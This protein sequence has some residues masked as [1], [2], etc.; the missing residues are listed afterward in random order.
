MTTEITKDALHSQVIVPRNKVFV[1]LWTD[2]NR[3]NVLIGGAGSGKSFAV[4][5]RYIERLFTQKGRNLLV[6]RKVARTNRYST[7]AQLKQSLRLYNLLD[8]VTIRDTDM[9]ILAP[10]GNC[11]VFEGLDDVEKIKSITLDSGPLTDIWFEEASEGT[12]DDF[13]LLN[14][15]LRGR[16]AWPFQFTLTLNPISVNHWV[17]AEFFDK[18]K[19]NATIIHSTYLD[20]RFIDEEYKKELEELKNTDPIRYQ[21]YALGEWGEIGEAAFPNVVF[22]PCPYRMEDMDSLAFGMDFGYQHYHA[23][24]V[25]GM[26]DGNLYALKELYVKRLLTSQIIELAKTIFPMNAKWIADS[27]EPRTIEEW[28]R[29]G[30]NVEAVD[31]G[32][33]D[34]VRSGYNF[35][36]SQK[37]FIDDKECPGL[38]AE[39]IGANY[40]KDKNGN[41]TE[42]IFSYHD[43]ALA[44]CRYAVETFMLPKEEGVIA[45][46][47]VW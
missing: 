32:R 30:F 34:F 42:E 4:S 6:V 41:P 36:R 22:S 5:Q 27:A 35:L 19:I 37:W 28:R 20:N 25:L 18:P 15:R 33:K 3:F 45:M 11:I 16:A 29:A 13:R 17:K 47:N 8:K 1:P 26:K 2:T 24:I 38:A 39:V 44:A 46:L 10:N 31:K 43:D 21:V 23:M 12:I 40:V 14:L 7:F 9:S